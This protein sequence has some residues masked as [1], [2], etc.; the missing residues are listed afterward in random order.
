[1]GCNTALRLADAPLTTRANNWMTSLAASSRRTRLTAVETDAHLVTNVEPHQLFAAADPHVVVRL[2]PRVREP[3][4][5]YQHVALT[6]AG[7]CRD[8][9]WLGATATQPKVPR[10]ALSIRAAASCRQPQKL[11]QR[12]AVSPASGSPLAM[13]T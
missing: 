11:E 12:R 13:A 5:R 7:S 9:M 3:A 10:N 8:S 2:L 1:M 6:T 4:G